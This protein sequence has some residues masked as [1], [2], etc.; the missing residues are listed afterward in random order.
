MSETVSKGILALRLSNA[1][2]ERIK[3]DG[4]T[5]YFKK[6]TIDMEEQLD[7]IAR[8]N[9]TQNLT[10]PKAPSE[11]GDHAALQEYEDKLIAFKQETNK[12]FRKVT[13]EIMK[14]VL[15][16]DNDRPLF[17]ADDDVFGLLNNVYAEKFFKAYMKFRQ[18]AEAGP[19]EAERRFPD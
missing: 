6:L 18:G 19:A 9:Q 13:A 2:G 14:Y 11:R 12:S 7:H 10:P 5:F 8:A 4:E 3:V 1:K 16:D 17:D 15:L